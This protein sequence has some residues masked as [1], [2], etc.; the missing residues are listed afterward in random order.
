MPL[1]SCDLA[2]AR[3][4]SVSKPM[5]SP[6]D[7]IS[8]PR[9]R[10]TPG[11][12]ANGNTASLTATWPKAGPRPAAPIGSS[13]AKLLAGHHPRRDLGDRHAGRLGDERHRARGARVDLEHVDFA[14]LDGELHIH[15]PDDIERARERDGLPLDLG[16][17]LEAEAVG[18]QRAGAVA[19]MDPGFLDMLH[20]SGDINLG[21]V[22]DGIDIDLDRVLQIA[23]DQDRAGA[24]DDR[25]RGGC[26]G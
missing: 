17:R 24:R 4:K 23:V 6:V 2:K 8:G 10:S 7:F 20:D 9:I 12:R 3:P 15:Q 18:R 1:P 19:G 25:P 14:V 22:G 26:S 5:T 21:A 16:D 13:A 11:K